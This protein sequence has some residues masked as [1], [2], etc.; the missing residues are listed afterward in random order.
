[1]AS[2]S[3]H[4]EYDAAM[5]VVCQ[6]LREYWRDSGNALDSDDLI[7]EADYADKILNDPAVVKSLRVDEAVTD[8]G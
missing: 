3:T 7:F 6:I 4:P 5:D 1:M 8:R 2:Q